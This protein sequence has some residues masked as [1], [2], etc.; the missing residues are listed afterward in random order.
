[1]Q[2]SLIA[3]L[4][5]GG[6]L[7]GCGGLADS[8]HADK[9]TGNSIKPVDVELAFSIDELEPEGAPFAETDA[10]GV[11]RALDEFADAFIAKNDAGESVEVEPETTT[12][13]E[14]C[15][16]DQVD[17]ALL[18][19]SGD[20]LKYRYTIDFLACS[21]DE[22]KTLKYTRWQLTTV[23]NHRCKGAD[24]SKYDGM[25]VIKAIKQIV[26]DGVLAACQNDP[27]SAKSNK[28]E[29]VAQSDVGGTTQSYVSTS[30]Y[31]ELGLDGGLCK[32]AMSGRDCVL[33]RKEIRSDFGDSG[34]ELHYTRVTLEGARFIPGKPFLA[35]A[36]A[37]LVVNDWSGQLTL[38]DGSRAPVWSLSKGAETLNG[39][40]SAD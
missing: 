27:E 8:K 24:F 23:E 13:S 1:M 19:A 11:D 31:S 17:K 12:E 14:R 34:D 39:T 6:L 18:A 29:F 33:T 16:Q 32:G 30:W 38:S 35:G 10:S 36:P 26:S 37:A 25:P 15:L 40:I 21:S 7:T 2:V 3:A 5:A 9:K 22:M 28:R 4:A 20:R